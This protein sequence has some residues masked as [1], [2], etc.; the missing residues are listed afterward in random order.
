MK[1]NKCLVLRIGNEDLQLLGSSVIFR[2][3]IP[4][5]F[6]RHIIVLIWEIYIYI[7]THKLENLQ[8]IGVYGKLKIFSKSSYLGQYCKH[9][10]EHLD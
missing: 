7:H 10:H 5:T 1:I 9:M 3:S 2:C 8:E 4:A 6:I